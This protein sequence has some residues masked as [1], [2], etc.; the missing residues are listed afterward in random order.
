MESPCEKNNN[1]YLEE[2]I[3]TVHVTCKLMC[4]CHNIYLSFRI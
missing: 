3:Q 2:N 1:I 4:G